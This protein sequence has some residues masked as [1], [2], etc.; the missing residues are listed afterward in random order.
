ME[1]EAATELKQV[2]MTPPEQ[3][4]CTLFRPSVRTTANGDRGTIYF[5]AIAPF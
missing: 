2:W 4:F 5:D 1:D 3:L